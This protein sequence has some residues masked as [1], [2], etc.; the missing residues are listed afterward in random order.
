MSFNTAVSGLH[1]AHKRMEVAGNNIANVHTSGFKS[2]RA[3]FSAVYS[4]SMLGGNRTASGDGVEVANVSQNFA[5]GGVITSEGR[6]L[7]MRIQGSGFFVMSDGGSIS[8]GRAGAFIKD[9][10]NFVVDSH[11][12]RLQG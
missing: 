5:P 9:A 11:G 3:E 10:Q 8:Y 12:S 2:S 6:A 7:D 1:A 4:S